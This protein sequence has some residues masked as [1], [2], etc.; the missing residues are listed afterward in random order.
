MFYIFSPAT[1]CIAICN[2]IYI[3]TSALNST[4]NK[5]YSNGDCNTYFEKV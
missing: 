4:I 3:I 5:Y 1:M 2:D